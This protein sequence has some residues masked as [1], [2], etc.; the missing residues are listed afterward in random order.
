[1]ARTA[2]LAS[3]SQLRHL[4]NDVFRTRP[5]AIALRQVSPA[6]DPILVDHERCRARDV[7]TRPGGVVQ[8]VCGD[9]A[10]VD[11]G[12]D[13]IGQSQLLDHLGVLLDRIDHD[14]KDFRVVLMEL[15]DLQL[16][17]L[18]LG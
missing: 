16:Q 11:I 5:D 8:V 9:H 10:S 7:A 13:A 12:E 14:R 4:G 1:M 6:D 18:Q 3:S 17:T 15:V 2:R